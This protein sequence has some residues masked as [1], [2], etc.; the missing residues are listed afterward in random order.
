MADR[1]PLDFDPPV[2]QVRDL[3]LGI[4]DDHLAAPTPC[5]GWSV[6]TLLD[7]LLGLGWAFT[8]AA[9]KS[10][11][12]EG[13]APQPS[14]E[15]LTPHWRSRLPGVL[16][17]LSNAWKDPAAWEGTSAAGGVTMPAE[18]TG[19]VAVNE[20]TMHGWD[21]ARAT[22]QEY[23]ADP[24]ILEQLIGFLS[25]GPAEGSPGLFGPRVPLGDE[26]TMLDQAVAL[27]GRD[28]HWRPTTAA[29]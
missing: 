13:S 5:P 4:T 21:L 20:L 23:A 19:M 15:H 28:P 29:H 12:G 26:A 25:A 10:T 2:R 9:R 1:V 8:Q 18:V 22:G 16:D 6:G 17:E 3:L 11:E 24:R 7:H 27:A 14:A